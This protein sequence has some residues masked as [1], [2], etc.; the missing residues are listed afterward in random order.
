MSSSVG[1]RQRERQKIERAQHKAERKAARQAGDSKPADG[2]VSTRTEAELIEELGGLHRAL[3][4]G[5]LSPADFE[6]QRDR[7]QAQFEQLSL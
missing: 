7:L 1:K 2:V 6:E 5:E 4:A 3:E